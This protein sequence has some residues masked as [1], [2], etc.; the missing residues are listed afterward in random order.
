[1]AKNKISDA[2]LLS[3]H[4]SVFFCK[5]YYF[6]I[7]KQ[8]NIS[9]QNMFEMCAAEKFAQ[10]SNRRCTNHHKLHKGDAG[11]MMEVTKQPQPKNL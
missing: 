10:L 5:Q 11:R 2:F 9:S 8:Y 4:Y 6:G 7:W 1:M 3:G